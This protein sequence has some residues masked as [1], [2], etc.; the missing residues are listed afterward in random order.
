M[1]PAAESGGRQRLHEHSMN[2]TGNGGDVVLVRKDS[3]AL[4]WKPDAGEIAIE[5]GKVRYLD[6]GEIEVGIAGCRRIGDQTVGGFALLGRDFAEIGVEFLPERGDAGKIV[7]GEAAPDAGDEQRSERDKP[8]RR[9]ADGDR[10]VLAQR[11]Y[12]RDALQMAP[13]SEFGRAEA[14]LVPEGA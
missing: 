14:K 7:T 2:G 12:Q 8:G 4:C 3:P 11:P 6:P 9:Q 5:V 10:R 1:S 13:R